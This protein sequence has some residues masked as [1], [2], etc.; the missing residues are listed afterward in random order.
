MAS[1]TPASCR[2][3]CMAPSTT[4][5]SRT[6]TS[7]LASSTKP[8]LRYEAETERPVCAARP[9]RTRA[10]PGRTLTEFAMPS[11]QRRIPIS[12]SGARGRPSVSSYTPRTLGAS[13]SG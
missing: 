5:P 9:G 13:P 1:S 12:A 4:S 7:S 6:G 10:R 11:R 2:R 8:T 3:T